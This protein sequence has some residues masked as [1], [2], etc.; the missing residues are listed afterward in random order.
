MNLGGGAE[1]EVGVDVSAGA[2]DLAEAGDGGDGARG[3]ER[4]GGAGAVI[5]RTVRMGMR[6]SRC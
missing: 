1:V 3:G 4:D 2:S 5:M 6:T